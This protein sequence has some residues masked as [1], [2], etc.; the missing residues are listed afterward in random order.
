MRGTARPDDGSLSPGIPQ[1]TSPA[2]MIWGME[3]GSGNQAPAA[4]RF[5]ARNRPLTG[6]R[7]RLTARSSE[8]GSR[9]PARRVAAVAPGRSFEPSAGAYL[10]CPLRA[11]TAAQ[12]RR[13]SGAITPIHQRSLQEPRPDGR[14]SRRCIRAGS[15]IPLSG[16]AFGRRAT[17][18]AKRF[19]CPTRVVAA[20]QEVRRGLDQARDRRDGIPGA[21]PTAIGGSRHRRRPEVPYTL[22]NPAVPWLPTQASGASTIGS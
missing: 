9:H 13:T 5:D 4:A 15:R 11:G 20:A 19:S 21:A 10:R 18:R 1:R 17:G 16:R 7:D 3:G 8:R 14:S 2:T 22:T 12:A 6:D